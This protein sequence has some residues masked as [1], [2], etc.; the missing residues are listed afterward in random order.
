[1]RVYYF[2]DKITILG[3][4]L[5]GPVALLAFNFLIIL[6]IYSAVAKGISYLFS[7][8]PTLLVMLMIIL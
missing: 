4:I 7:E 6:L 2:A 3:G 8:L 5:S 1:M